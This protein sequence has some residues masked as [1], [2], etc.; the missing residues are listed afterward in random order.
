MLL[1]IIV[2]YV[3]TFIRLHFE[4]ADEELRSDMWDL[5]CANVEDVDNGILAFDES[6]I[7]AMV[8]WYVVFECAY[9]P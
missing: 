5:Y 4:G 3:S 9:M 7:L 2:Q 1:V 8:M 6:I